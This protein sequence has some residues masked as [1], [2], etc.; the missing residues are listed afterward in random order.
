MKIEYGPPG[1]V[2]VKHLQYFSADE[3]DDRREVS[4]RL[5]FVLGIAVGVLVTWLRKRR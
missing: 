1:A 4:P 2:G 5:A 3:P